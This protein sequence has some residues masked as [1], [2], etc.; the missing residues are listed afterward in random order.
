MKGKILDVFLAEN[1]EE[2]FVHRRLEKKQSKSGE[3]AEKTNRCKLAGGGDLHK[4]FPP[5]LDNKSTN[6]SCDAPV[7][8][9]LVLFHNV[10][11][12]C[13]SCEFKRLQ[14]SSF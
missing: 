3:D 4:C 13:L 7:S 14:S 6:C 2:F 8:W 11:V 5:Y 9:I 1:K 10:I 12:K